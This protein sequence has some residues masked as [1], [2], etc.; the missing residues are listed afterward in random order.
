MVVGVLCVEC[1]SVGCISDEALVDVVCLKVFNSDVVVWV[2]EVASIKVGF[3]DA[4]L[5]FVTFPFCDEVSSAVVT[6]KVLSEVD[7]TIVE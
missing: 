1:K 3:V 5:V 7:V 2:T 6:L 4:S